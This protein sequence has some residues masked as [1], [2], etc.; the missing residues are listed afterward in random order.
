[1]FN[2]WD[3]QAL[4]GVG[5]VELRFDPAKRVRVLFG[6][7]GVGKTKCLEAMFRALLFTNKNLL[8]EFGD[9]TLPPGKEFLTSISADHQE[10]FK[11]QG[12]WMMLRNYPKVLDHEAPVVLIGA[13]GRSSM[14]AVGNHLELIGTFTERKRNY[15]QSLISATTKELMADIGMTANTQSWFVSRASS[16][17]PYQKGADNRS[18]E[19]EAVL[20]ILHS[21]DGRIHP[22]DLQVDG[23]GKV[24]LSVDGAYRELQQLSSGFA[25]L[26]KLVQAIISGYANFTNESNLTHV[27]GIVLI[28]EIESHLHAE[29]QSKI[30]PILKSRLPNT[31]FYVATHSPIVLSQ[32]EQG[33]AY[34]LQRDQDGVVRTSE[35]DSPNKRS[36]IDVLESGFNVDLNA[37]KRES[38]LVD[39]QSAAKTRL[40]DLLK[41]RE[42]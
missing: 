3:I 13:S 12:E 27:A 23:S 16:V 38:M 14:P 37:L 1:M 15:F 20:Q 28:D 33:E 2:E 21:I 42:G 5:H 17:N 24:S 40:L 36:F 32:L 7:N 39:D 18:V 8:N 6:S 4:R 25:S 35:I 34:L 10:I 41:G 29:W 30:V 26:I 22:K 11:A 19:I 9:Q 31:T